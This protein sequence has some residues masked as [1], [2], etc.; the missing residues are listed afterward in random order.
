MAPQTVWTSFSAVHQD[1]L[2]SW[3]EALHCREVGPQADML[4]SSFTPQLWK[5]A[6]FG[7]GIKALNRSPT[8]VYSISFSVAEGKTDL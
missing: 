2:S 6:W 8:T 5:T 3:P 1:A 4:E 7:E